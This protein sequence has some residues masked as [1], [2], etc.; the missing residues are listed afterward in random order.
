MA[1]TREASYVDPDVRLFDLVYCC[2]LYAEATDFDAALTRLWDATDSQVDLSQPRHRELT[3]EW[4]RAWGCR[5]LR[6]EDNELTL[7]ALEAW[8]R[9]WLHELHAVD[10]TLDELTDHDLDIAARAY[11]DLASTHAA[12]RQLSGRL[13]D[14]N[15]GPTAA[16]KT[17]FAIRPKALLPWDEAIRR[18]LGY[19][20][21][22][23]SYRDAIVRARREL[24]EAVAD[25]GVPAER[26]PEIV[27]R[28]ASPP[29]KLIDEH[30]WVRHA[31]GHAPPSNQQL[32]D[33]LRLFDGPPI[34]EDASS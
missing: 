11:G 32:Q 6:R 18:V 3:V 30:D 15:F 27:G 2:R 1:W 29:P 22:P 14:V 33:W 12:H 9:R 23:R 21:H 7:H 10:A 24:S 25:A 8:W 26:L 17:L 5:T 31:R 19:D 34:G 13:A 4:L 28:P 16:A 20:G